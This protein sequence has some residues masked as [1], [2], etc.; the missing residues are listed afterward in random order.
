[1]WPS[2]T[3]ALDSFLFDLILPGCWG[4]GP[5]CQLQMQQRQ[6]VYITTSDAHLCKHMVLLR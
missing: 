4:K 1:M 2:G 5:H 3:G 6:A